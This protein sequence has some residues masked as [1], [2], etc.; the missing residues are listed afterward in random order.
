MDND[1]ERL[2]ADGDL[3]FLCFFSKNKRGFCSKKLEYAVDN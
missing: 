3:N 2:V 1:E